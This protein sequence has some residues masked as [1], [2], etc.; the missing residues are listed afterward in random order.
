[1]ILSYEIYCGEAWKE[2]VETPFR[3]WYSTDLNS[4]EKAKALPVRR[5]K[6]R[7]MVFTR[8]FSAFDRQNQ[9][10]ANSPFHGFYVLFWIA[11][12]FLILKMGADNW[13]RTGNVLGTNEIMKYMFRRDGKH[14]L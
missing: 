5:E 4:Q 14:I 8:Q 12:A 2:Y 10:A 6:L 1:M 13:R 11:V 7:D 9:V 3:K